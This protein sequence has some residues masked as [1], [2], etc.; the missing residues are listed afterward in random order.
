[1]SQWALTLDAPGPCQDGQVPDTSALQAIAESLEVQLR[2]HY[3]PHCG[4]EAVTLRVSDGSDLGADERR[5]IFVV[6]LP[7]SPKDSRYHV[8]GAAYCAVSTCEDLYGPNGLSVD[9]SHTVLEGVGNPGCDR[10]IEDDQGVSHPLERCDVVELQTY[11]VD[12]PR[13]GAVHVS[14]FLLDAWWKPRSRGPFSYMARMRLPGYVEPRGPRLPAAGV[15]GNHHLAFPRGM[16]VVT[17]PAAALCGKPRKPN[18]AL[19]WTS[20]AVRIVTAWNAQVAAVAALTSSEGKRETEE[21]K[22]AASPVGIPAMP[23]ATSIVDL[24]GS[25]VE[26]DLEPKAP[27]PPPDPMGAVSHNDVRALGVPQEQTEDLGE[28]NERG[29]L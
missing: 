26:T 19:H 25:V 17:N 3:R 29:G 5:L 7:R 10:F 4:G 15:A 18:V 28:P 11:T 9:A 27:P 13:V 24:T 8:P 6:T 16:G 23:P 12:H 1:M 2:E 20:R 22:L 14:N 21:A